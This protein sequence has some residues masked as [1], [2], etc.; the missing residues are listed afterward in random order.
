MSIKEQIAI[1]ESVDN[2]PRNPKNKLQPLLDNKNVIVYIIGIINTI[3]WI[4]STLGSKALGSTPIIPISYETVFKITE[5]MSFYF[6]WYFLY[7]IAQTISTL[8]ILY[9]FYQLI[10][11]N[12]KLKSF[13]IGFFLNFLWI[14]D[15][16][17]LRIG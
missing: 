15:Y 8:V 11:K 13:I 12:I 6:D 7:E 16:I 17:F 5:F 14:M 1:K 3:L 9:S 2:P 4:L 10:K